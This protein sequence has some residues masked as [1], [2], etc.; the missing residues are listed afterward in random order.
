MPEYNFYCE[1]CDQDI[2]IFCSISE[3]DTKIKNIVCPSC[4]SRNIYRNYQEDNIYSNVKDI[5]TVGQLAEYNTKKMGSKLQ[6][7]AD[8]NKKPEQKPWYQSSKYGSASLKEIN[9]MT[10]E[11]KKKYILGGDK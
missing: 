2:E 5:R 8:K 10:K 3:Y 1:D 11:Q 4:T 6:E 7:E 9:K